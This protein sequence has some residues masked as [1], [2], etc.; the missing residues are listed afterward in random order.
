M[1]I[2]LA[3]ST[4][5]SRNILNPIPVVKM[6][7]LS[8]VDT[9]SRRTMLC[10]WAEKEIAKYFILNFFIWFRKLLFKIF[11]LNWISMFQFSINWNSILDG[12]SWCCCSFPMARVRSSEGPLTILQ[13]WILI[14][15][16]KNSIWEVQ[17]LLSILTDKFSHFITTKTHGK[18]L[19]MAKMLT[20]IHHRT[21]TRKFETL[22][23]N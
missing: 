13:S 5:V 21:T 16:L 10:R 14:M 3:L 20:K 23:K 8:S 2:I 19:Q 6:C 1:I 7:P 4:W 15:S 12:I 17:M 11:V 22:C 18:T 9:Q